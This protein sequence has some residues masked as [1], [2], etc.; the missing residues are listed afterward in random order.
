[1][2]ERGMRASETEDEAINW[3]QTADGVT[4]YDEDNPDAWIHAEFTAG[5]SPEHRLYMV[6]TEC[7][8]IFA[9]RG[10]PGN[11][12]LCGSCGTTYDHDRRE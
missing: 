2:S 9:Q 1:M 12:T 11:G 7:G 4:I 5:V 10:K 6:C 8:E 3:R